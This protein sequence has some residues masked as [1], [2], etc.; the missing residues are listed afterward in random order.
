ME[1]VIVCWVWE[2]KEGN[3]F[4]DQRLF[5]LQSGLFLSLRSVILMG[6]YVFATSIIA[7]IGAATLAASEIVR[8]VSHHDS[9]WVPS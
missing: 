3:I 7:G 6:T 9:V 8:Q 5:A 1:T 4:A 2:G